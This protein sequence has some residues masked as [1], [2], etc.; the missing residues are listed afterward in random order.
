[1]FSFKNNLI[2]L[3]YSSKEIEDL[4]YA[5][6]KCSTATIIEYKSARVSNLS[7]SRFEWYNFTS[8]IK[9]LIV[10]LKFKSLLLLLLLLLL[11]FHF[12]F[13]KNIL[14]K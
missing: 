11:L 8:C 5:F 4:I 3:Y 9:K 13:F 7:L 6:S 10:I 1:M 14:N 12:V 2:Y